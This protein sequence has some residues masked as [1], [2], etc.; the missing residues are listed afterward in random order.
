MVSGRFYP[1]L[2][3]QFFQEISEQLAQQFEM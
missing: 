2:I 1:N 3:H